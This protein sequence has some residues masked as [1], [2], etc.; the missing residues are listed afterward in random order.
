MSAKIEGQDVAWYRRQLLRFALAGAGAYLLPA[1]GGAGALEL[2]ADGVQMLYPT[3][4]GSSFRLSSS[5][6][7]TL[8]RLVI[9]KG[10][11]A[12]AGT[13]GGLSFWNLPSYGLDYSSGGSGWTSRLNIHASGETQRYTWKTQSGYLSSPDDPKNQELTVYLR[14]HQILDPARAQITLKIRGGSHSTTNPERASCVLMTYAPQGYPRLT[15]FGKELTHPD[16]DY[17]PLR[18]LFDAPLLE[19][20]W[21]GLKMVSWNDPGDNTRVVNQLYFDTDPFDRESGR[22]RNGWRLLSEYV[23]VDGV[24]SGNYSQLVNWGGWQTTV[25][26]DGFHDVDFALLSLREITPP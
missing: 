21:V 26:T 15:R 6:P 13:E 16:Y 12:T 23:D 18:P 25:R 5:D 17:V 4:P 14:I 20:T 7:N 1:C 22:P 10:S 8:P 19:N 2:D 3:A 11:T 24:S 9:E